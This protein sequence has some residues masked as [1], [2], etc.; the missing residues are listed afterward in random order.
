MIWFLLSLKRQHTSIV[1]LALWRQHA[2]VMQIVNISF[3]FVEITRFSKEKLVTLLVQQKLFNTAVTKP[4]LEYARA[5]VS[6]IYA[7]IRHTSSGLTRGLNQGE[8]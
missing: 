3:M 4:A 6:F 2:D 7:I 1:A 8:T 5:P